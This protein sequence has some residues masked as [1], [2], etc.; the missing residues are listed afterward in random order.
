MSGDPRDWP[1]F[2]GPQGDLRCVSNYVRCVRTAKP[3]VTP[4]R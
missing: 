3:A 1:Q 2:F 4:D